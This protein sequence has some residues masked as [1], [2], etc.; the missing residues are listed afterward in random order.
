[1]RLL[2]RNS[3]EEVTFRDLM[4]GT[5]KSKASY[6]KIQFCGDAASRDGL[7]YFWIDTCYIDKSNNTKLAE[8]INSMFRW[9][10][11][12]AKC[13]VYLSVVLTTKV[14]TTR[15]EDK[16]YSLLGIFDVY[17]PLI[18]DEGRDN[19]LIRL[20]EEFNKPSKG[21]DRLPSAIDAPFNSYN[22]Q[23]AL[24]WLPD[25][26]VDLLQEI[27]N[28]ADRQDERCIFWLNGLAGTG[29][30]T[31][32]RTVARRYFGQKCLG[33]S[34]FFSRGGGDVGRADKFVTSIAMQLASSVCNVSR[35][36]ANCSCY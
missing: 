21:L 20:R 14:E 13:Y 28:W 4:D 11:N 2:E 29:K 5:G 35:A 19:A 25:T 9:Y 22:K 18:Y 8:A 32:T 24:I 23:H 15:E 34:F 1:M 36:D 31:I 3:A 16:A 33:A 6:S 7:Q 26:R 10:R 12:A 30:S 17:M 27:Y